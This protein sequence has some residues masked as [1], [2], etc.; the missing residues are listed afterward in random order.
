[1][2]A[3]DRMR[4]LVADGTAPDSIALRDV[5]EPAPVR[6]EVLVEVR[7]FSLNPG[8]LRML[9]TAVDGWRPGWDFA[10]ILQS[11]I[12]DGPLAGTRVVGIRQKR[13][14]GRASGSIAGLAGGAAGASFLRQH[15]AIA[16]FRLRHSQLQDIVDVVA[17]EREQVPVGR[18][19]WRDRHLRPARA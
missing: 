3:E 13:G 16:G 7:A 19:P 10:G 1:M 8:E 14:L 6:G 18:G 4:A 15:D 9:G 11:D 5:P 2:F 12:D 17:H